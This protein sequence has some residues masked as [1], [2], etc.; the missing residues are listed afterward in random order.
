LDGCILCESAFCVEEIIERMEAKTDWE[1]KNN[2]FDYPTH[3][4]TLTNIKLI[5][6]KRNLSDFTRKKERVCSGA[7]SDL[8]SLVIERT[9]SFTRS[10]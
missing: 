7:N 4:I 5:W 2:V 3:C 9:C 10:G 8:P 6:M 1:S